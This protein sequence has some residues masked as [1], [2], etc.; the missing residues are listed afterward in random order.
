MKYSK[1]LLPMAAFAACLLMG[2]AF[3]QDYLEGEYVGRSDGS[4]IAQYFTDPIFYIGAGRQSWEQMYYPYFGAEFF[5]DY[6][7]PNPFVPPTYTG[8]FGV[9]PFNPEP[10]YSDF[11]LNSLAGMEWEP[12]KKNWS[13][14][15]NYTKTSSS[16]RVYQNGA[17]ITP[18][19]IATPT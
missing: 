9:Y 4:E 13:E 18:Q 8:P 3:G 19:K 10:Y 7:Q 12:F 6:Y 1:I 5:R 2:N 14:T 16:L 15:V 11:R 17:W